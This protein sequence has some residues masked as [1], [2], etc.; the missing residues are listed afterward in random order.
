[1]ETKHPE[2]IKE[3]PGQNIDAQNHEQILQ[4]ASEPRAKKQSFQSPGEQLK[5]LRESKHMTVQQVAD[6]LRLGPQV[7]IDIEESNFKK[8]PGLVYAHGYLQAYAKLVGISEKPILSAFDVIVKKQNLFPDSVSA[9]VSNPLQGVSGTPSAG[10][11]PK[12]SKLGIYFVM[13]LILIGGIYTINKIKSG[14]AVTNSKL[15][16]VYELSKPKHI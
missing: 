5:I 9:A 1:M 6:A 10:S 4:K 2:A 3:E 13:S 12:I 15:Q 7:V 11:S 16:S 8:L 14:R